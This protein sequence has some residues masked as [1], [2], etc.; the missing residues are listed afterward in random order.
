MKILVIHNRYRDPGGED[1]VVEAEV[2]MLRQEAGASV[3]TLVFDNAASRSVSGRVGQS[4]ALL[5]ASWSLR[6]AREVEQELRKFQPDL[7][8]VH[9][10][11]FKATPS[12][13]G[14]V[15]RCGVPCVQTLHNFRLLCVNAQFLREGKVCEDCLGRSV[16]RGVAHRCY[17]DSLVASS[18]VAAMITINRLRGTWQR[19]V[20]AF[21]ALT[22][23]SREKFIQAGWPA[24]RIFLKPN[25][26]MASVAPYGPPSASR[27]FLFVGRLSPEKGVGLLLEAWSRSGLSATAKLRIVGDGPLREDLQTQAAALGLSQEQV[28]FAGFLSPT[29]VA[30]EIALSRALILPSIWY[31]TFGMTI[32]E[33]AARARPALVSEIGAL[34]EVVLDGVTGL[35]FTPGDVSALALGLRRL[36]ASDDLVDALGAEARSRYLGKYTRAQ[37]LPAL[38]RIYKFAVERR[39]KPLPK[40][41]EYPEFPSH[42]F[43]EAGA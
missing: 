22:A 21:I 5:E 10:F 42:E 39:N 17:K 23:H 13:H 26:G 29:R 33:A 3:R 8:H 38:L 18:S 30:S 35:T 4:L 1:S 24:D 43:S 27:I 37:N 36:A 9:N 6:S 7:V 31:E 32:L 34:P 16:L 19:E 2:A 41:L 12:V 28:E 40:M 20:D 25:F 15:A 14:M 11:W